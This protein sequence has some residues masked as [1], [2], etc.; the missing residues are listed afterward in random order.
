MKIILS[1][2]FV[3]TP[4]NMLYF[5]GVTV[6]NQ[7]A[8]G[9]DLVELNGETHSGKLDYQIIVK[10]KTNYG[11][12]RF[13][14]GPGPLYLKR[15]REPA[16][17]KAKNQPDQ[18]KLFYWPSDHEVYGYDPEEMVGIGEIIPAG[19]NAG[20]FKLG[21]GQMVTICRWNN[22]ALKNRVVYSLVI[23]TYSLNVSYFA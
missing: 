13:P 6:V 14:Q 3:R 12:G 10:P 23:I 15:D 7:T 1:V 20:K 2:F 22:P 11:E 5:N 16:S 8:T 19:P 21:N 17:A 9:F 4:V 18:S